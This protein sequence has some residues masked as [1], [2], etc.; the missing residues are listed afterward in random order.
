MKIVLWQAIRGTG[1][2]G[3]IVNVPDG[4]ARN[5]LIPRGLAQP[6][7]ADVIKRIERQRER[8][9][10]QKQEK[11]TKQQELAKT[12]N[13]VRVTVA[14]STT[15]AGHLFGSVTASDIVEALQKQGYDVPPQALDIERPLDAV[16]SYTI[17]VQ[18]GN[19]V[20]A[21]ITVT[22]VASHGE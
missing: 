11:R 19:D 10:R 22:I 14:A 18:L 5:F 7:T 8:G 6:A 16:G 21:S 4:Y 3:D 1:R 2:R 20:R 13:H 15:E 12:L 9:E 17:P